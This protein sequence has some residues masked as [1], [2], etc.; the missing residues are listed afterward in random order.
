[1]NKTGK[2]SENINDDSFFEVIRGIKRIEVPNI[3]IDKRK[4]MQDIMKG[5]EKPSLWRYLV[6]VISSYLLVSTFYFVFYFREIIS[7]IFL[8]YME[9]KLRW[10]SHI[11]VKFVKLISHFPADVFIM[12]L[13]IPII[14]LV[15][16]IIF[17]LVISLNNLRRRKYEKIF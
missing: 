9:S 16:I 1:M 5:R 10:F 12:L 6:P 4:I 17:K 2:R 3:R 7:N 14:S 8:Y 15:S 11:A 13:A